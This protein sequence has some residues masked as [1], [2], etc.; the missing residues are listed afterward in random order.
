MSSEQSNDKI[1]NFKQN[2]SSGRDANGSNS[3]SHHALSSRYNLMSI[4]YASSRRSR[5]NTV[6]TDRFEDVAGGDDDGA[7]DAAAD[8]NANEEVDATD[9]NNADADD[10]VAGDE[11]AEA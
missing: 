9:D 4:M 10:D 7:G 5:S 3:V 1:K 8:A 2:G 11:P 6:S